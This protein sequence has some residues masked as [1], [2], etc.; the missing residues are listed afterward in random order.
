MEKSPE[1]PPKQ[2]DMLLEIGNQRLHCTPENTF[3]YL[4]EDTRFD[5]LFFVTK[6]RDDG[7]MEGYHI[8]RPMLEDMF[9]DAIHHMIDTGYEVESLFEPDEND[10]NAFFA[11][12]KNEPLEPPKLIEPV[13]LTDRLERYVTNTGLFLQHIVV[14]AE[15][16]A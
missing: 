10:K 2:P 9:D 14:T 8:W 11:K 3:G 12:Y 15:D 6:Q 7:V 1:Q 13:E 5:H 16:F 4:Y